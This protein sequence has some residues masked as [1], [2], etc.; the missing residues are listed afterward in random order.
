[1]TF[2]P[3][4]LISHLNSSVLE[5]WIQDTTCRCSS[6]HLDKYE[7]HVSLKEKVTIGSS[8][9]G[10]DYEGWEDEGWRMREGRMREDE[11]G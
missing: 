8:V 4:Q 2:P 10:E 7:I 1:M 11:G 5:H 9:Q 6:P 3:V